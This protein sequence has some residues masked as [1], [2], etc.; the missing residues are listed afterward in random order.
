MDFEYS[1]LNYAT[2]EDP[3]PAYARLREEAP[4]YYN[5]EL[6]FWALSRHEDVA[7]AL[8]DSV[9]FSN[10]NGP[11]MEREFWNPD[12]AKM[13]SIV[14]MDPPDHP[15]WRR[16]ISGSFSPRAVGE[17]ETEIRL[18]TRNYVEE[19]AEWGQF[20]LMEAVAKKV[21]MD[22]ISI[23]MGVPE[24]DRLEVQRLLDGTVHRDDNATTVGEAQMKAYY[25]LTAYYLELVGERRRERRADLISDLIDSE[26]DERPLTDQ[27]IIA[28]LHLLGGASTVTTID[29]LGNAWYWAWRNPEQQAAAL[30]GEIRG[31]VDESLRY[32]SPVQ[33]VIRRVT[34][35]IELHGTKIPDGSQILFLMGAANRDAKVFPDPDR[36]DITRRTDQ[37]LSF[38]RG[39]HLCL[40]NL[41]ARK[42][43]RIVLE[44][45]TARVADYDIDPSGL[46]RRHRST[47]RGFDEIPTIITLR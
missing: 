15:R 4:A 1:P 7:A 43:A 36:F 8:R 47:I 12:S 9:N 23:V 16:L 34:Q 38:S 10:S 29:L 11:L 5:E 21:P 45:L 6:D 17:L 20:D 30:G 22:T 19:A 35:D 14:A 42:V 37:L 39:P 46:R 32:D 3:Y 27:E 13:H 31:W 40:G 41:L 33:M 44:E 2:Q 26:I 25:G 24:S 18:I 28:F